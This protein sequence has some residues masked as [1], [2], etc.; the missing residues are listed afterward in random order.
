MDVKKHLKRQCVGLTEVQKTKLDHIEEVEIGPELYTT[1]FLRAPAGAHLSWHTESE[2]ARSCEGN[3]E[4]GVAS[5][6]EKA[7][8]TKK[9]AKVGVIRRF[10]RWI[11]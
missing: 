8:K 7:K 2:C 10:V 6:E 11:Y 3:L 5:E 1:Q 4:V 9:T